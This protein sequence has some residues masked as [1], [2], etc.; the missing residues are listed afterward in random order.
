VKNLL[1][2]GIAGWRPFAG[3]FGPTHGI[4]DRLN[5]ASVQST[6]SLIADGVAKGCPFEPSHVSFVDSQQIAS[7]TNSTRITQM[8][9]PSR[10]PDARGHG[11][12]AWGILDSDRQTCHHGAGAVK[13]F[14]ALLNFGQHR[15]V[16]F[17]QGWTG[18]SDEY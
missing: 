10:V 9:P 14:I 12:A 3:L 6:M 5:P 18:R 11:G 4:L 2:A 7:I 1:T 17:L 15:L 8:G 16:R 13:L